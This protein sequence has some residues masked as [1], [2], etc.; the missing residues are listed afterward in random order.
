[1]YC[2]LV[3]R[4]W[5]KLLTSLVALLEAGKFHNSPFK[6]TMLWGDIT[7]RGLFHLMC[8]AQLKPELENIYFSRGFRAREFFCP[9]V[10]NLDTKHFFICCHL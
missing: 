6:L 4:T 1:M 5:A 7:V 9:P 8:S 10:Q 3:P 2:I